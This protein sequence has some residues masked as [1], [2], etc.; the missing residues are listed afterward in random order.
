MIDSDCEVCLRIG[1][2]CENHPE[3][4]FSAEFGC[5]CGAGM[6]CERVRAGGL[7]QPDAGQ[8]VQEPIDQG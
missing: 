4:A 3:R 6:P 2:V 7:E 1:W 8:A 5:Q